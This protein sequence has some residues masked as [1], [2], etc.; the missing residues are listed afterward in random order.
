MHD[1]IYFHI[2]STFAQVETAAGLS[3]GASL[4]RVASTQPRCTTGQS[5]PQPD[6]RQI[7]P[8]KFVAM[9]VNRHAV[10]FIFVAQNAWLMFL[11][12]NDKHS[13]VVCLIYKSLMFACVQLSPASFA[14]GRHQ[15]KQLPI[16]KIF[17]IPTRPPI[18][19]LAAQVSGM[20]IPC[21]SDRHF[22]MPLV[23]IADSFVLFVSF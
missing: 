3:T 13:V 4:C 9:H 12:L 15:P 18:G 10:H 17:V 20:V 16:N 11:C 8:Q 7:A 22:R 6:T 5:D 14:H 23:L 1:P 21:I 19:A 2:F